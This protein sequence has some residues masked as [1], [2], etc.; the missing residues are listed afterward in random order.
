[1]IVSWNNY[2]CD[3][4]PGS[5][6][7]RLQRTGDGQGAAGAAVAVAAVVHGALDG[8]CREFPA[9]QL[10]TTKQRLISVRVRVRVEIRVRVRV[11][12]LLSG[13]D[14]R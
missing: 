8:R 9:V 6:L 12:V 4:S 11:R 14:L 13:S 10:S 7:R 5:R 3:S 2:E 1:M